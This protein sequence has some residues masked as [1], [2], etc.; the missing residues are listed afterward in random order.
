MNTRK[1][2]VFFIFFILTLSGC[3]SNNIKNYKNEEPQLDLIKFFSGKTVGWGIVQDRSG[4]V[5]K[6]F[7]VLIDGEFNSNSGYLYENFEWSDGTTEKRTWKLKKIDSNLW[8]GSADDVIGKAK[9]ILSGNALKWEYTL[10]LK[11]EDK[12]IDNISVNFEDWMYLLNDNLLMNQATFSK[13]GIKLG[14]ITI[15]FLKK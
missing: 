11:L 13:L 14:L 3:M 2:F 5:I 10:N 15:T 4:Q 7:K 1:T 9:G 12:F 6:R 8:E